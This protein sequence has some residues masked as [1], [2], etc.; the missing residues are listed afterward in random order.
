MEC[1]PFGNIVRVRFLRRL[2]DKSYAQTLLVSN[3]QEYE[4]ESRFDLSA[5]IF[6]DAF[7]TIDNDLS[8]ILLYP[9]HNPEYTSLF[10]LGIGV[11][12][13]ADRPL[14][15]YYQGKVELA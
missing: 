10:L 12:M 11:H 7:F 5:A 2:K 1:F 6:E 9:F 8:G 14:T 3:V 4:Q 15:S 13:L